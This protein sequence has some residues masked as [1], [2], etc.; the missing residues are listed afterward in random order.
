MCSIAW[1]LQHSLNWAEVNF[2]PLSDTFVSSR[3]WVANI[4]SS[5]LIVAEALV[6][7]IVITSDHLECEST[8]TR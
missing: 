1:L 4:F 8:K 3:P 7:E 5:T 2:A 6:D